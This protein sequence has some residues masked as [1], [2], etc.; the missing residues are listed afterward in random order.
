M[1]KDGNEIASKSLQ[2]Q[3]YSFIFQNNQKIKDSINWKVKNRK[4]YV[5]ITYLCYIILRAL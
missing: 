3:I 4:V 1:E 2:I 5:R